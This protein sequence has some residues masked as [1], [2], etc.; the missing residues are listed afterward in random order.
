LDVFTEQLAVD[1]QLKPPTGHNVNRSTE[2]KAALAAVHEAIYGRTRRPS[3]PLRV[4]PTLERA[5]HLT[6]RVKRLYGVDD[7]HSD[8]CPAAEL[9][10]R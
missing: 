4:A 3:L 2:I 9:S 7:A 10:R 1:Y 5:N 8:R 6:D